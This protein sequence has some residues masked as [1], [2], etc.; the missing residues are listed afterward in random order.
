MIQFEESSNYWTIFKILIIVLSTNFRDHFHQCVLKNMKGVTD[1]DWDDWDYE[2][3][4]GDGS[5]DLLR[6]V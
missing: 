3:T 6:E 5:V 2:N 1:L 4:L